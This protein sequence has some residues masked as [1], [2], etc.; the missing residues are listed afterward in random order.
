MSLIRSRD[1]TMPPDKATEPPTRLVPDPRPTTGIPFRL[2]IATTF[3]TSVVVAGSTAASTKPSMKV[4][5]W[6]NGS[7][8]LP[9]STLRWPTI[10]PNLSSNLG[11]A[12][13]GASD[14]TRSLG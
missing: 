11:A 6:V 12:V 1:G 7:T 5:S 10:C 13:I 9:V 3:D 14:W 8:A 4:A 2:Q